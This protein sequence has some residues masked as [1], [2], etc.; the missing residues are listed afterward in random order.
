[1]RGVITLA[2]AMSLPDLVSSGGAFPQRDLLIFLSFCVI[3]TTLILQGLSLP[4]LIRKLGLSA[5]GEK[6]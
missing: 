5:A 2:A 4:Y 1:M 3:L 6:R